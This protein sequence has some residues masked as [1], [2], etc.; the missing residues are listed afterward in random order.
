MGVSLAFC[1]GL[2]K[3]QQ[4][5]TP[6]KPEQAPT[7]APRLSTQEVGQ[8]IQKHW[9]YSGIQLGRQ[10]VTWLDLAGKGQNTEF[11]AYYVTETPRGDVP[12]VD[13]FTVQRGTPENLFHRI[14]LG[15]SEGLRASHIELSGKTFF[16]CTTRS[17]SGGYL[18]VWIYEYDG[19]GK[20]ALIY[21]DDQ[22]LFQ[23]SLLLTPGGILLRGNNQ[24]FVLSYD[25]AKFVRTLYC[26]PLS[27]PK[28]PGTHILLIKAQGDKLLMYYDERLLS[29]TQAGANRYVSASTLKIQ[30]DEQVLFDENFD[31]P[32]MT[33]ILA[34]GQ[35]EWTS[36]FYS[37]VKPSREGEMGL[38]ISHD[39]QDWYDINFTVAPRL[40]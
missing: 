29:F 38:S 9:G 10:N 20:L 19:I 6:V 22:G 16:L 5:S 2:L 35:F 1:L 33:R 4:A 12:V 30:K 15:F 14:G 8:V 11:Y 26:R 28:G 7:A 32:H 3:P 37:G 24:R 18:A 13:V 40:R 36:G 23:G 21:E 27:P 31:T 34:D 39:Y 25:G 17:G